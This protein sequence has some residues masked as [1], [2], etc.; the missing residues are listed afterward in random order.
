MR[1]IFYLFATLFISINLNGQTT[2]HY[3]QDFEGSTFPPTGWT[4]LDADE[5]GK[6]W[7]HRTDSQIGNKLASSKS[8]DS[9]AL[10]PNNYIISD[11]FDFTSYEI[12]DVLKLSYRIG[13]TGNNYFREH[14]KLVISLTGNTYN[15]FAS[16]TVL[17]EETLTQTESGWSL[18]IRTV[19]IDSYADQQFWLAWVHFDCT[20]QDGLLLDDIQVYEG[21]DPI[22]TPY[23]S[24]IVGD[25]EDI[26][27]Q[28]HLQGIVLAGGGGDNSNAMTWFLNRADGGDVVVIRASGSDGYNNYFY[29]DLG[30]DINSVE[31]LL[32]NSLDAAQDP[33]VEQQ[34]RNA[35]ALFIGGGD[36]YDYYEFW[37]D[38]PVMDAINYL[39]NDKKVV[40]G[41]TSAGMAILGKAY[42]TPSGSSATSELL[43]A[44]P[45]HSSINILGID[46][47]INVPILANT[48]TDTHFDNRE[49]SGRLFTFLARMVNDWGIEAKGIAANEYTA[50]CI[51]QEGKAYVFGNQNYTDYAYFL[52]SMDCAPEVCELNQPLTWDCNNQ[53]VK[54]YRVLGKE[55]DPDYFDLNTWNSGSNGEWFYWYAEDGVFYT[56]QISSISTFE[57][58]EIRIYP[59]PARHFF[60][61]EQKSNSGFSFDLYSISG[62]KLI[63]E[64]IKFNSTKIDISSLPDG[65]YLIQIRTDLG[66]YNERIIVSK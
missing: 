50:V 15:D 24:W 32:I 40:V 53:A 49:R 47:F 46:D 65:I 60:T 35:E 11:R 12:S 26:I 31:T 37:K 44:N 42:Y 28:N 21:D 10:T 57:K 43:L 56:S 19:D 5:D 52:R 39:I 58:Q 62:R 48:V 66:V 54:V 7:Y 18:K 41:G 2:I 8:Y 6:S 55:S 13:A 34:I 23:T 33:Y 20:N 51:D 45:Y 30:V 63:S 38:T 14:Y 36:Q 17:F 1:V 3:T 27:T 61:I 9:G 16:G 64:S 4:T 25:E 29:S 22:D 59:N